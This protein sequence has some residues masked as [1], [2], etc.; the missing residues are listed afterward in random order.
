MTLWRTDILFVDG[1]I[2]A[3]V[4]LNDVQDFMGGDLMGARLADPAKRGSRQQGESE[5][6][7]SPDAN[8]LTLLLDPEWFGGQG[9][10]AELILPQ[11]LIDSTNV[12]TEGTTVQT[13]IVD[14]KDCTSA[15]PTTARTA[16]SR[17][18]RT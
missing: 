9:K 5:G 18:R 16:V 3:K 11:L 15:P 4:D 1:K 13:G 10:S 12:Q 2:G 8:K 14:L 6:G 17:R 7:V